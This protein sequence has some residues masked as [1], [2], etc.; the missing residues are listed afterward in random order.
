[1]SR[2]IAKAPPDCWQNLSLIATDMDGTITREGKF[3]SELL[4]NLEKIAQTE[5]D[6]II[7]TG[8]SAGWVDAVAHYLPI[9]GAIA[10]NGG[11]FYDNQSLNSQLIGRI[12]DLNLHRQQLASTFQLLQ[13]KFPHLKESTD[14]RFRLTDWTFDVAELT[15]AEL[16]QIEKISQQEGWS[17]TYSTVQCHIKPI[18]QDKAIALEHIL[19]QYYPQLQST[20]VVTV[21]DSPNDRSLFDAHKFPLSVGVANVLHYREQLQHQP[22][23]ITS[24]A[25]VDGFKEL[26]ELIVEGN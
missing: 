15:S 2:S 18:G 22:T 7:V 1:M 12:D 24:K 20:Q 4:H 19:S 16:A 6:I 3:T 13:T 10:E 26:V 17:F 21:G 23:Y 9:Q 11:L 8:R 25:E 14:N 5:I